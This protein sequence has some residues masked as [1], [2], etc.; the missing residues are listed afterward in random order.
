MVSSLTAAILASK[1]LL[2]LR[3]LLNGATML[4]VQV[5]LLKPVQLNQPVA[6]G[7]VRQG[8][9]LHLDCFADWVLGSRQEVGLA[10][11]Q[12]TCCTAAR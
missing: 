1:F 9:L 7:E 3:N 2:V 5:Q 4:S 12:L 11:E 6:V 10:V 8:E